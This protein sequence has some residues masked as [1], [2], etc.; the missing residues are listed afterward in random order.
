P[1][2][3]VAAAAQ[4]GKE[5]SADRLVVLTLDLE[6]C[7]HLA[8]LGDAHLAFVGETQQRLHEFVEAN[9]LAQAHPGQWRQR[10][11]GRSLGLDHQPPRLR[12]AD[13]DEPDPLGEA[14]QAVEIGRSWTAE[15]SKLRRRGDR[16]LGFERARAQTKYAGGQEAV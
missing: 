11:E 4:A 6:Q 2:V 5:C 12:V 8:M 3:G 7:G 14:S 15:V 1:R 10:L 13:P 9:L 16:D